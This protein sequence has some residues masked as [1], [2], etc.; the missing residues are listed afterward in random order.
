MEGA[1]QPHL[2]PPSAEPLRRTV[3]LRPRDPQRHL[4]GPQ[5]QSVTSAALGPA[6][7]HRRLISHH[8]GTLARLLDPIERTR[9]R[10]GAENAAGSSSWSSTTTSS[11]R[12][13]AKKSPDSS[14]FSA[15]S[16]PD[17]LEELVALPNPP[18]PLDLSITEMREEFGDERL[19]KVRELGFT[20][21][22][23]TRFRSAQDA[24]S[25]TGL[26]NWRKKSGSEQICS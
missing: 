2:S 15:S 5:Q 18:K 26:S 3:A 19:A 11:A 7:R 23:V 1:E 25:P 6:V 21:D 13:L 9:N 17:V 14:S 10:A 8:A 24:R 20:L 22:G 16:P 4:Y 12:R